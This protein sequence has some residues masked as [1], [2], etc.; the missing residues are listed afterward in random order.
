MWYGS[1]PRKTTELHGQWLVF[2]DPILCGLWITMSLALAQECVMPPKKKADETAPAPQ[3]PAPAPAPAA[4]AKE[5]SV[6]AGM[7][8][9]M[10]EVDLS[11]KKKKF[12]PTKTNDK[13]FFVSPGE[14]KLV[15]SK[16][17]EEKFEDITGVG[18]A[19]AIKI[20]APETV[21]GLS[22]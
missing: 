12:T 21:C 7:T 18:A 14:N 19:S 2:L 8:E 1:P 5:V 13:S 4:E 22:S 16:T 3:E 11:G 15:I 20:S 17:K 6:L 9:N 10:K